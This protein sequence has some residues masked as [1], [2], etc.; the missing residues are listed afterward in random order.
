MFNEKEK[1]EIVMREL[2]SHLVNFE[3]VFLNS[4]VQYRNAYMFFSQNRQKFSDEQLKELSEFF[5][6]VDLK[7]FNFDDFFINFGKIIEEVVKK[8]EQ[9]SKN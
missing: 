6:K 3:Q 2:V 1:D 5:K 4:L 7:N 8:D 9:V